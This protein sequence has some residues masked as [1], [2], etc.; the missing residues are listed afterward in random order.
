[1]NSPLNYLEYRWLIRT[2]EST[3]WEPPRSL[4]EKKLVRQFGFMYELSDKGKELRQALLVEKALKRDP[5]SSCGS[6]WVP[7]RCTTP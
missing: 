2:R 6:Y 7:S 3:V 4:I 1:M 5:W